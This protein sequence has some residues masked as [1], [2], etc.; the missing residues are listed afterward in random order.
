M[1]WFFIRDKGHSSKSFK[2]DCSRIDNF[3]SGHKVATT[4]AMVKTVCTFPN[5]AQRGYSAWRNVNLIK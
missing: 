4:I 3:I 1:R 5:I 2:Y